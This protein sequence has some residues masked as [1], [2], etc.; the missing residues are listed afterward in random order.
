MLNFKQFISEGKSPYPSD[1]EK[2]IVRFHADGIRN[3]IKTGGNFGLS[4]VQDYV[5][6][7][8]PDHPSNIQRLRQYIFA[9]AAHLRISNSIK[10]KDPDFEPIELQRGAGKRRK[11]IPPLPDNVLGRLKR[12][13]ESGVSYPDLSGR[14]GIP[15]RHIKHHLNENLKDYITHI[16]LHIASKMPGMSRD[17]LEGIEQELSDRKKQKAKERMEKLGLKGRRDA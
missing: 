2:K 3:S 15:I 12:A 6:D 9:P 13:R 5:K 4:D 17:E 14:F 11:N 10:E 8:H 7:N 1:V 16:A